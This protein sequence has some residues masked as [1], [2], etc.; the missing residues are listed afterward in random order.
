[1]IY[2]TAL[3]PTPTCFDGK[4]NQGEKNIDCGGPCVACAVKNLEP[5][6]ASN[7]PEIF[8]LD[9]GKAIILAEVTN[10]NTNYD[11]TSFSYTINIY[12]SSGIIIES[13]YGNDF[14]SASKKKYI[15]QPNI[16]TQF[17]KIARAEIVFSNSIWRSLNEAFN[18]NFTISNIK[19]AISSSTISISGLAQNQS[20]FVADEVRIIALLLDSFGKTIFAGQTVL[21]RLSSFETREFVIF[22]PPDNRIAR[23]IDASG[24]RVFA[25]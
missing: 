22:I 21:T 9:S 13:K 5:L 18:P 1:M 23:A 25:Y 15:F 14:I 12:N 19:T 7:P 11:A 20:P 3:V 24:T 10:P 4:Q 6:R 16:Q 2:S 8:G 17:F